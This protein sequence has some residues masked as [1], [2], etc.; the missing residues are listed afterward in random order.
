[1][2]PLQT[3]GR[4]MALP[5]DAGEHDIVIEARLSPLRRGF[6]AL[7]AVSLV[8]ALVLVFREHRNYRA[9]AA[10][11]QGLMPSPKDP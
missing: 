11:I 7:A 2:R 8:M 3:A 5:L 1:M 6:L 10:G 4:F 9:K